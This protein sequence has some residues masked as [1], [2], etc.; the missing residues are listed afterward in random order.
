M[1]ELLAMGFKEAPV[2]VIDG[3]PIPG[4]NPNGILEAMKS[5]KKMVPRDPSETIPLIEK[6]MEAF[7]RAIRQMP[8]DKLEWHIPKRKRTMKEAS[9]NVF[10]HVITVLEKRDIIDLESTYPKPE[11]TSF[12]QIAGWGRKVGEEFHNWASQQDLNNLRKIPSPVP[13]QKTE[14]PNTMVQEL[15][16]IAGQVCHHTRQFYNILEGFGITPE[17][18]VQDSELPPEYVLS[19]L[20]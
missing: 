11:Y 10:F 8:D 9:Q 5:D 20:W 17:K 19:T 7:E 12:Q 4:F 2:T 16:T 18:R 13:T 1:E 14:N 6:M 3:K 15:D